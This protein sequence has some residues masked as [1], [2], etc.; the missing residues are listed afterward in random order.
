MSI[1]VFLTMLIVEEGVKDG[2]QEV[3]MNVDTEI[4]VRPAG[5]F[6]GMNMGGKRPGGGGG[7]T[8]TEASY[9]PADASAF[10]E[11]IDNVESI[12]GTL[13]YMDRDIFYMISAIEPGAPLAGMDGSLVVVIEGQGLGNY[14]SDSEVVVISSTYSEDNSVEV[15]DKISLNGTDV[16]VVGIFSS[17]TRFGGRTMFV[18]IDAA[19]DIYNLEGQY[20]QLNVKV[21]SAEN[22]DPVYEEMRLLLDTEELDVVHPGDENE[23]VVGSLETISDNSE[24][25]AVVALAVGSTIVFFIMVLVTRE[26]RREIGTLKALG[27]SD[28]DVL[29]QF[30][31][32]TMTITVI[33]AAFGLVVA[34]VAGGLIADTVVGEEEEEENQA[35]SWLSGEQLER[36]E[37]MQGEQENGETDTSD[38]MSS[39]S[40]GLSGN[41][42]LYAFAAALLIG[43]LG[44]L[45]PAIQA[46]KM[47]PVEALRYE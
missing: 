15:G 42:V 40:Y 17:E 13:S 30:M 20:S 28:S 27:A 12:S 26:R 41:S 33:G 11:E 8:T 38:V 3:E 39:I 18:P 2:I 14:S 10:I 45:Y 43:T 19:Q 35:P 5:S 34:A 4:I 16:K 1:A 23:E 24:L 6:G 25:G 32:E 37:D 44:I 7:G 46:T 31:V 22:L 36:W 9:V 47:R 21:D 29:R